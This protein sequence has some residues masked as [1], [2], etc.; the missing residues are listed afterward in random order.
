MLDDELRQEV[1][2]L[3]RLWLIPCRV[4]GDGLGPPDVIDPDH[5]GLYVCV[6]RR[7]FQVQNHKTPCHEAQEDDGDFQVSVENQR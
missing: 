1:P 2:Q 6:L 5:K 3:G 4:V 7:C